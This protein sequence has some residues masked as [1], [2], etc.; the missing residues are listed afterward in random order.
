MYKDYY[1]E[2]LGKLSMKTNF[3]TNVDDIIKKWKSVIK[4]T[5]SFENEFV[6][7]ELSIILEVYQKMESSM[8]RFSG[9]HSPF[10]DQPQFPHDYIILQEMLKI[11][12]NSLN[13]FIIHNETTKL[14]IVNKYYN[15]VTN[16]IGYLL[17]KD[18]RVEEGVFLDKENQDK[19]DLELKN[20]IDSRLEIIL[21][22]GKRIVLEREKKLKRIRKNRK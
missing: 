10:M 14:N 20:I 9:L 2:E 13:D 5:L 8:P 3:L 18:I 1:Y 6:Y 11:I 17:E 15:A 19:I 21:S 16:K 12:N 4:N 22:P 7:R